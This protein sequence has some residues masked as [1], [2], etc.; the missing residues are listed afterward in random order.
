[1]TNDN[2]SR[3]GRGLASL[4]GEANASA[5]AAPRQTPKLVKT[6]AKDG[7]RELAVETIQ[8]GKFNPRKSFAEDDLQELT[9]SISEKG[10]VQPLV[11]RPLKDGS[12]RYEIVA[13]ERRWRAAQRAGVSSIPVIIREVGDSEA[14][15]IAIIENVQRSDLNPIEEAAGYQELLD[16][17]SYRQEDLAQRIGKSRSHLTNT[18]RLLKLPKDVQ[19]LVRS[20]GLSAGHARALVGIANASELAQ[21]ITSRGLSVREAEAMAQKSGRGDTAAKYVKDPDTISLEKELSDALGVTVK[22]KQGPDNKG[23]MTISYDNLEQFEHL[24][25]RLM[26]E[27]F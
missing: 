6:S 20:G 7:V 25:A 13:G 24:Y 14:L 15:E 16:K 27:H 2:K 5:P 8:P 3:L 18:L 23:K 19:N 12:G 26:E 21:L 1:M 22:L 10:L 17:F 11:V 9:V 4:I